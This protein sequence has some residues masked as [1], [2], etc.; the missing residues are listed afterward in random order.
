MPLPEDFI[1]DMAIWIA[2]TIHDIEEEKKS[3]A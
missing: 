3:E 2:M 1:N